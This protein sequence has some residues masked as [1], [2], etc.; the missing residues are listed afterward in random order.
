MQIINKIV[1]SASVQQFIKAIEIWV[2]GTESPELE[3]ASASYGDL[4]AFKNASETMRFAYDEGLPGKTWSTGQPIVLTD[5]SKSYFQRA[6]AAER[7]RIE[8]GLSF[9]V[10]C[11][12]FLQAVVVLFCGGGANVVGAMEVWHNTTDSEL[13]LI[14]GYYGELDRFE[15]VSR[16]L[17]IMKGRGLPGSAWEKG[18]PIIIDDIGNS[19]SF[20]RASNAAKVGI[21]TG[22]AIPFFN[23]GSGVQV[24]VFLSAKGTPIA[25]RFEIWLPDADP[26]NDTLRFDAGQSVVG[27]DLAAKYAGTSIKKGEG[28]LGQCWLTGRPTVAPIEDEDGN[29]II[30]LP[31]IDQGSLNSIVSLVL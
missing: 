16:R 15:W 28:L 31:V 1:E 29:V 3:L 27:Q 8:C 12:D 21:T 30:V 9:P 6:E 13:E 10:F 11:G 18:K 17:S 25:R 14:D 2:P 24:L 23:I 22:L 5:F 4:E 26:D 7:A 19:N 20:L